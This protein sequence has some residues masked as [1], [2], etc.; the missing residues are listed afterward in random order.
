MSEFDGLR[1]HENTQHALVGLGSA[2]LAPAVALPRYGGQKFQKEIIS[3]YNYTFKKQT[4]K[5]Q[6]KTKTKL[7]YI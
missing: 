1:K 7:M 2:T 5:I 3:V 6:N 4:P